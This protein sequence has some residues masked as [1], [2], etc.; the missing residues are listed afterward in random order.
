M[1]HLPPLRALPTFAL[2]VALRANSELLRRLPAPLLATVCLLLAS[3]LA[4]VSG[5]P[6]A[7]TLLL[8][9]ATGAFAMATDV[10]RQAGRLVAKLAPLGQLTYSIYLWH[11]M[12]IFV[13]VN[14]VADKLFYGSRIVLLTCTFVTL[15]GTLIWSYISWRWFETPCRRWVE[16]QNWF[17]R[18]P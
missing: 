2:G 15:A 9:C 17:A 12:F 18:S 13:L 14:V 6:A 1:T 16:R 4:A 8:L 10:Q 11:S 3:I 7:L 5:M